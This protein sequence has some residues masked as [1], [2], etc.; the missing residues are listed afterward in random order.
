VWLGADDNR[1]TGL[2]GS[3]GALRV[4]ASLFAKLPT[5]PLRLDLREDPQLAWVDPQAQAL[6][7][8]SCPG[9]RQLPF[10][11]GYE[12]TDTDSCFGARIGGWFGR[13][14]REAHQ[15]DDDEKRRRWFDWM[16]RKDD[17]RDDET[18]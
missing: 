11:R 7:D 14:E 18:L 15:P 9:A 10:I 4:W 13:D 16:R 6:S 12:P 3:T 5:E 1:Q 2:Y 8:E 17:D